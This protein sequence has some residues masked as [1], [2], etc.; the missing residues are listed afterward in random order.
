[1]SHATGSNQRKL[2]TPARTAALLLSAALNGL[3]VNAAAQ[4]PSR[5][6]P[7]T[8]VRATDRSLADLER[9]FWA[10]DHAATVSGVV[11]FPTAIACGGATEGLRLRRF[12]GD[13][14]AMLSWWQQNKSAEHE[15]LDNAYRVGRHP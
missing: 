7:A 2:S 4:E 8:E 6:R 9:A 10:C 5:A 12:N 13:F 1:M 3:C 14:N 11:D 15:A